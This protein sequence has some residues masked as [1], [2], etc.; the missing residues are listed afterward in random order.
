MLPR[1]LPAIGLAALV[2]F[3]APGALARDCAVEAVEGEDVRAWSAGAWSALRPGQ[4]LAPEAK[5]ATGAGSRVKIACDDG[6]VVT[7][8]SASE[9][10]LEALTTPGDSVIVQLIDGIVGLFAPERVRRFEVRTPL[11]IASVRS[12]GWL[13]EHDADEGSAVFVRAGAVAVAARSGGRFRLAPGEGIT[14]TPDGVPGEVKTWGPPRIA[15]STEA[16]GFDWR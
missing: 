15:R 2:A 7:V 16:L 14:I 3:A 11:A 1:A 12:T 5:V 9:V 8:G 13:V 10:N 4:S 6:I